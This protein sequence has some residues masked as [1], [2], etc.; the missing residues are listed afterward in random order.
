MVVMGIG[1]VLGLAALGGIGWALRK[2][3]PP[4]KWGV[5]V[6]SLVVGAGGAFMVIN[7]TAIGS[8]PEGE[9]QVEEME[10]FDAPLDDDWGDEGW[11]DEADGEGG[12]DWAEEG[13]E[14]DDD[15]AEEGDETAEGDEAA[16]GDETAEGD[17]GDEEGEETAE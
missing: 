4:K 5:L 7:A 11:G 6:A 12:D 3:E 10:D 14:G 15:W 8:S 16:E 9:E 1:A 17:E 13:G 2:L